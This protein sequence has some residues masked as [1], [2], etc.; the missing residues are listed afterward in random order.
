MRNDRYVQNQL[1]QHPR[2]RM[3][4]RFDQRYNI[5]EMNEYGEEE[6]KEELNVVSALKREQPPSSNKESIFG[7]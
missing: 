3:P 4:L 2:A 7:S 5:A 1:V 6:D